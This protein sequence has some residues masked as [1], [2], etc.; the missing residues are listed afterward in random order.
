VTTIAPPELLKAAREIEKLWSSA[1]FSGIVGDTSH[2]K[3]ASKHNSI[4]DNPTGSSC[5]Y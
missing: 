2:R 4:E 1:V 3:R 5:A